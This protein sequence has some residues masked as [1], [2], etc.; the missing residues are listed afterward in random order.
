MYRFI[1]VFLIGLLGLNLGCDEQVIIEN[2]YPALSEV[3][4]VIERC[5]DDDFVFIEASL[6]DAESDHVDLSLQV[7]SNGTVGFMFPGSR[8][9]GL[10]GLATS[11][12]GTWH[13]IQW[14]PCPE[15]PTDCPVSD[16][17]QADSEVENCRCADPIG[18]LSSV[19]GLTIGVTT[20]SSAIDYTLI[21]DDE[22]GEATHRQILVSDLEVVERELEGCGD[23]PS[24]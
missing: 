11:E 10:N 9:V 7:T 21:S 17:L 24:P 19:D 8:G 22:S 1:C 23:D 12:A 16:R 14:A 13:R 15:V 20:E 18:D 2:Q 6:T 4:M 5:N 3:K